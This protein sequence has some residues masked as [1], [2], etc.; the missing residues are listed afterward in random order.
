M[1]IINLGFAYKDFFK[2]KVAR[3][4]DNVQKTNT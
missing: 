4:R 3:R 2:E 1:L